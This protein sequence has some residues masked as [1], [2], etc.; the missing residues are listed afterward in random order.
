M[1]DDSSTRP[2]PLRLV[3]IEDQALFRQLTVEV[4]RADPRFIVVGEAANGSDGWE[5]CLRTRPDLVILDLNIPEPD[6]LALC[7]RLRDELPAAR[8]LAVTSYTDALTL[9]RLRD[10]GVAGYVEKDQPLD[11]LRQALEALA[12]GGTFHTRIVAE[13]RRRQQGDPH[14]FDKVL[15][16]REQEILALIAAGLRNREI[17]ERLGLSVRTVEGHRA[18]IMQ[19]LGVKN[20]AGL[21][22]YAQTL[23]VN[24][25]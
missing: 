13:T 14:S 21:L 24:P 15:S 1:R 3:V 11:T 23:G 17:A 6:G 10:L 18:A 19:K 22:R 7:G 20:L 16:S 25:H 5:L 2:A 8:V 12:E 9:T 4:V